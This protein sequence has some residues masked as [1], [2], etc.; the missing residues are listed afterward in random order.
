[1]AN[2]TVTQRF[3]RRDGNPR[4]EATRRRR[5]ERLDKIA[6][7]VQAEEFRLNQIL[8]CTKDFP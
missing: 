2:V 7:C 8:L 4:C 3:D 5:L 1:M 6:L